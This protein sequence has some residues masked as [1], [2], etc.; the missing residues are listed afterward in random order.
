MMASRPLRRSQIN[1]REAVEEAVEVEALEATI[2]VAEAGEAMV[3]PVT[4]DPTL[5]KDL[6]VAEEKFV[7]NRN[8]QLSPPPPPLRNDLFRDH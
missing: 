2:E 3:T 8:L 4:T 6:D 1:P 7:M 5:I